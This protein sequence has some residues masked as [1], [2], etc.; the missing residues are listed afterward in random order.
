MVGYL[1]HYFFVRYRQFQSLAHLN[2]QLEAWLAAKADQRVHGIVHEVVMA[3]FQ[4]DVPHLKALPAMAFDTRYREQ[5]VAAW[6]GY[7]EVRG[8]RYNV[9][10]HL[11]A[12]R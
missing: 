3:R 2:Q 7:V 10:D 6:D 4:R 5:R 9:P 11:C 8:N 12:R 1:K